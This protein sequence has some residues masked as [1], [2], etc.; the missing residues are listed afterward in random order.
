MVVG[1]VW[2]FSCVCCCSGAVLVNSGVVVGVVWWFSCV[3]SGSGGSGAV[4]VQCSGVC[5]GCGCGGPAYLT[6]CPPD[7]KYRQQRRA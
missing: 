3:C 6:L 2:W 4:L 1:V 5:S 7:T